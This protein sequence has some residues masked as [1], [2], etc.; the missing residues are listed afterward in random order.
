MAAV[1]MQPGSTWFYTDSKHHTQKYHA[2]IC[3]INTSLEEIAQDIMTHK[4]FIK[5]PVVSN[6][7]GQVFNVVLIEEMSPVI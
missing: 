5:Y 2:F 3:I 6:F 1:I 4:S 7:K